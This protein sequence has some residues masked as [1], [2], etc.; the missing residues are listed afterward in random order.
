[1]AYVRTCLKVWQSAAVLL[2]GGRGCVV[3]EV[4]QRSLLH[5]VA[6]L[7]GVLAK[8]TDDEFQLKPTTS[9]YSSISPIYN[10]FALCPAA[11]PDVDLEGLLD[12][13]DIHSAAAGESGF[14]WM[15]VPKKKTSYTRKRMRNKGKILKPISHFGACPKCGNLK[16]RHI[17]CAHCLKETLSLTAEVRRKIYLEELEKR[18]QKEFIKQTKPKKKVQKQDPNLPPELVMVDGELL[19]K[20]RSVPVE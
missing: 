3:E 14:L 17:L 13:V 10:S 8:H 11:L 2:T 1:M 20:D 7:T 5:R 16:L 6:V 4:L 12:D 19:P 18:R 9:T 15:A